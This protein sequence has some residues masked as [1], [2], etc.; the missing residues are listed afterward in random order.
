MGVFWRAFFGAA[1]GRIAITVILAALTVLGFGVNYWVPPIMSWLGTHPA[2]ATLVLLRIVG[3]AIG[4]VCLC[5]IASPYIWATIRPRKFSVSFEEKR[6]E[7]C[8]E[9]GDGM[10]G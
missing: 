3:A 10:K 7:L 5:L 9:V 2:D 6:D 1:A 8:A 4:V